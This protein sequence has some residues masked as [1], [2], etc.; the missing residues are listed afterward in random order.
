MTPKLPG[1]INRADFE[2]LAEKMAAEIRQSVE[3]I[4]RDSFDRIDEMIAAGKMNAADG[5]KAKELCGQQLEVSL[6]K[7]SDRL[8]DATDKA[9]T[10][11]PED[12]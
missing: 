10:A 2:E 9:F 12:N 6:R 3:E 11:S 1:L 4:K 7:V 8:A 5:E